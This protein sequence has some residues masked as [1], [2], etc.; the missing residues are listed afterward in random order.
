MF[1]FLLSLYFI[2][3]IFDFFKMVSHVFIFVIFLVD[4]F[5]IY[6]HSLRSFDCVCALH[7]VLNSSI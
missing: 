5:Y 4:L 2:F 3:M 1:P 7:V 6:I